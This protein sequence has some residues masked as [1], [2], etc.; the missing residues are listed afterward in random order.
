MSHEKEEILEAIR[1]T[2]KQNG[3]RP[4]GE[5][6]FK[7]ETGLKSWMKYWARFGDAQKDAG[8]APN[9]LQG[10]YDDDFLLRKVANIARRLKRFPTYR[11]IGIE[12]QDDP[13]LPDKKTFCRLGS[14][15]DLATKLIAF[16]EIRGNYGDVIALS[17]P[18]LKTDNRT[19]TDADGITQI[20]EVYLFRSGRYY[21]IGKTKD[22][23]RR[24]QELRVQLP[25]QPNLIHSIKTDDP[26][27]VEAYWHK[28]FASKRKGG[29]WFDL[30]ASDVK[31]FKRWQR[32]A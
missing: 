24:G 23:V 20:G 6:R 25:E 9:Q 11:E 10:A 29:E 26:S 28:R 21:K 30:N 8:F 12:R 18:I 31:A 14:K 1:R 2:A 16:C 5:Q 22:T 3:G 17:E 19:Q 7:R 4:L 32:I 13:E 27:G 15:H